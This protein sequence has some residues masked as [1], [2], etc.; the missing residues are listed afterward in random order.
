MNISTMRIEK[1]RGAPGWVPEDAVHYLTH[2]E[3]GRSIRQIARD[4]GCHA[5]TISRRIRRFESRR[6][7][8]LVDR[9][10]DRLGAVHFA[11]ATTPVPANSPARLSPSSSDIAK[12]D[13]H[14]SACP[15]HKSF[16]TAEG[17]I[18]RE[19]LRILR[20][21][22]ETGA[23]LAVARDMDKAVVLRDL[24]D[25]NT[26]RTAVVGREVA[27][28]LALK[29]W[30]ECH[31]QGA[32]ARYRITSSGRAK[33]RRLAAREEGDAGGFA[34][35]ASPFGEQHRDWEE[36][37]VEGEAGGRR[38]L[39]FNLSES[40]LTAV[41]RRRDKDGKP[42]L[43][44]GLVAAGE[45]LREDFELAQMGPRVA[46]NWDRFLTAGSRGGPASGGT[47]DGPRAARERVGE[48]LADL[49]PGLGDVVLRTCCFLEGMETTER[50][51]GWS[52]RSGKI[53]LRIALQRLKAHYD[54]QG[55]YAPRIG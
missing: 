38:R 19:A 51:M 53:V 27:E 24:P 22:A 42:F 34:E 30:I 35:A 7:D 31:T 1:E 33:L 16:G 15:D 9:A 20:R 41:A 2:I 55:R 49:G 8:P 32:I 3:M 26:A 21:L 12:K 37:E 46:Q 36:R 40:P 28:A 52:A 48:A 50:H 25:G 14:M 5:S 43:D 17:S 13:P 18:E 29:D 47:A 54:M 39:R 10:L 11:A 6:D 45:R 4:A 44:H 23:I